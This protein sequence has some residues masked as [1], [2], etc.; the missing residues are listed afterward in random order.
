MSDIFNRLDA[1]QLWKNNISRTWDFLG[2]PID[3]S[4]LCVFKETLER[5]NLGNNNSH[6]IYYTLDV[7]N[8]RIFVDW[9]KLINGITKKNTYC[10]VLNSNEFN[11]NKHSCKPK[12]K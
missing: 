4:T 7:F 3:F 8:K 5:Q 12:V 11:I 1:N 10:E 9:I 6:C 2:N